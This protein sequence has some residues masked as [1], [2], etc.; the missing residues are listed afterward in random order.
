MIE[1]DT[2]LVKCPPLRRLAHGRAPAET[3]FGAA[4]YT[5]Q[6]CAVPPSRGR[7]VAA[8]GERRALLR[9]SC[10]LRCAP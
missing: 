9:K 3:E 4:R 10:A 2:L 1:T 5:V 7:S 6:M 8:G